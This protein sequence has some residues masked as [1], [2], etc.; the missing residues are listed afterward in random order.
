M[1]HCYVTDTSDVSFVLFICILAFAFT[2]DTSDLLAFF[3]SFFTCFFSV[4]WLVGWCCC[5]FLESQSGSFRG[6]ILICEF[7]L[8]SRSVA[9][10]SRLWLLDLI[11]SI[12]RFSI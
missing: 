12:D 1:L 5:L 10:C 6:N 2:G 9:A 8:Y 4:S 7:F 3:Y 11:S